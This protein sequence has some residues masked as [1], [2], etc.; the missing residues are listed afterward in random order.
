MKCVT[1]AIWIAR[2]FSFSPFWSPIPGRSLLLYSPS[3]TI[4]ILHLSIIWIATW[5]LISSDTPLWPSVSCGCQD[6]TVQES[7]PHKCGQESSC[8]AFNAMVA[9]L[10]WIFLSSHPSCRFMRHISIAGASCRVPFIGRIHTKVVP[11]W[12]EETFLLESPSTHFQC[13]RL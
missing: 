6:S 10:S 1:N 2:V 7:F 9:A 13:M 8:S 5:V 12:S 3:W 11:S 4:L